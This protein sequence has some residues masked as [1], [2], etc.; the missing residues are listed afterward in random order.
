MNKEEIQIGDLVISKVYTTGVGLVIGAGY[1]RGF[2]RWEIYWFKG[3]NLANTWWYEYHL[4]K[5]EI[6]NE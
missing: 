4:A 3:L 6:P 1:Y 5:L 2:R